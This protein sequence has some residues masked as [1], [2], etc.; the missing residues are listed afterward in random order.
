[1]GWPVRV[2]IVSGS[3]CV[4]GRHKIQTRESAL[5]LCTGSAS[6]AISCAR[7]GTTRDF[8]IPVFFPPRGL[9]S[10]SCAHVRKTIYQKKES[11]FASCA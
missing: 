1:M 11:N 8:S 5:G 10:H 4:D 6:V 2:C 3:E 9:Q 7:I